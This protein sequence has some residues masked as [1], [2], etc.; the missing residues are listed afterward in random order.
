MRRATTLLLL[1]MPLL[2][3]YGHQPT[4][5]TDL[6]RLA[7]VI[8]D[9]LQ[10]VMAL[11]GVIAM[12]G[13]VWAGWLYMTSGGNPQGQERARQ[14]AIAAVVGLVIL[15]GSFAISRVVAGLVGPGLIETTPILPTPT[16][17]WR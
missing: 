8:T 16:P 2:V 4:V 9:L 13:L 12:A 17:I 7:R 6:E 1:L 10:I 11:G 3:G 15:L 14:A 5:R